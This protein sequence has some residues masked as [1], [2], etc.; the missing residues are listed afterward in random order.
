MS[1][2]IGLY[3]CTL[4]DGTSFV[5]EYFGIVMLGSV[6]SSNSKISVFQML[7]AIL[8]VDAFSWVNGRGLI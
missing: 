3:N 6:L 5:P 7:S 1:A 4:E 2:V 8:R